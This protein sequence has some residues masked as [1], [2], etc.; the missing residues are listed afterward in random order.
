MQVWSDSQHVLDI[1]FRQCA[2]N[3][4]RHDDHDPI[5]GGKRVY[6]VCVAIWVVALLARLPDILEETGKFGWTG[7]A[8]VCDVTH[9]NNQCNNVGPF[10]NHI[11]NISMVII[12]YSAVIINMIKMRHNVYGPHEVEYTDLMKSISLTLLLLTITY[13]MF[14]LPLIFFERCSLVDQLSLDYQAAVAS[15]YWWLYGVNFLTYLIS[16]SRIR[17][18]YR[19]FFKDVRQA[20]WRRQPSSARNDNSSTVFKDELRD[21]SSENS[22]LRKTSK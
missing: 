16:N 19:Q 4:L 10:I 3:G 6:I 18:A 20:V 5:F 22:A 11:I 17:A 12:F 15:W 8:F 1:C 7:N 14:L 2:G 9:T 13:L 21:M